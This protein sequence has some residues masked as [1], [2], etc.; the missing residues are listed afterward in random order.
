MGTR[1]EQTRGT[2]PAVFAA[3][4]FSLTLFLFAPSQVYLT[5]P[6]DF[7]FLWP[8]LLIRLTPI[9]LFC[10]LLL[11]VL[12]YLVRRYHA[13]YE[14]AVSL[15]IA[16]SVLLWVQGN[17][18]LYRLRVLDGRPIDWSPY[19]H[20]AIIE[21]ALWAAVLVFAYAKSLL[22]FRHARKVAATFIALQLIST[23]LLAFQQWRT[24]SGS[25]YTADDDHAFV[26]SRNRNVIILLLDSFRSDVF[27][28]IV[29][30]DSTYAEIFDGF[31][32][33]RN[34]LG[35]YPTTYPSVPLILTGYHYDSAVP[36]AEFMKTCYLS[37]SSI[38][39]VLLR[40]GYRVDLLAAVPVIHMSDEVASNFRK[41]RPRVGLGTLARIY[42]VALLRY[43]PLLAKR[44]LFRNNVG[45]FERISPQFGKERHVLPTGQ[46]LHFMDRFLSEAELASP[47][48]TF[49]F[50][51]LKGSHPPFTLN[52]RLEF[53]NMPWGWDS[54]KRQ[55]K[56]A[57]RITGSLLQKLQELGIY[58]ASLIIV[59]AD[60]GLS[61]NGGGEDEQG[62]NRV[63]EYLG[64]S[65]GRQPWL[66]PS[67]IR[68][69]GLPLVLV[70]R[71]DERGRMNT[72]DAPVSLGDIPR[73]IAS[74]LG[75]DG[76]FEGISFF[77][78]G[79]AQGRERRFLYY[80]WANGSWS[81][82]YL[83]VMR[84]YLVTGHSWLASSW[85][86]TYRE[87]SPGEERCCPPETIV[88]GEP[89]L[90]GREGNSTQ[91]QG[92]GWSDHEE[93]WTWTDGTIAYLA[94]PL[95]GHDK[96]VVMK[97]TLAPFLWEHGPAK[98]T[99][100]I[101]AD[102]ERIGLWEADRGGEYAVRIPRE[103]LR[104]STLTIRFELPDAASPSEVGSG[105]DPRKLG[106]SMK[107]IV[108]EES[109]DARGEAAGDGARS[110]GPAG[111]RGD[112]AI[113]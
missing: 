70:K 31:T 37:D 76:P 90:F 102:G 49:K 28:E 46:D 62:R 113:R 24:P 112:A 79:E 59:T 53:E 93:G 22:L 54:Y 30:E 56:G 84:E 6:Q 81:R 20:Y 48:P 34:A 11:I 87:F 88:F 109:D 41:A 18:L 39:R 99:V 29:A 42:D 85:R 101:Y 78:V 97:A 27:Q 50:Y 104:A 10:A 32:F 107:A 36:L 66:V 95:P 80:T 74:E 3:L 7:H 72:S 91:Y 68:A 9:A 100:R 82:D 92:C 94:I 5:N 55:A 69:R 8:D 38:P 43:A 75:M 60:T 23:G 61:L 45:P 58:D 17:F 57:L 98:Q 12:L 21:G 103:Y 71:F 25:K 110:A 111:T 33:F 83:P 35:G 4:F 15:L 96:D 108:F 63:R 40:D 44:H 105:V 2:E 65:E 1:T 19:R 86:P 13:V 67:Q 73:T 14:K 77:E 16:L 64:L 47:Q 106:L 51:C 89:V 52:E 26:F